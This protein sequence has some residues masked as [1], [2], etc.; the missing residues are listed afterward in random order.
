[1]KITEG[2]ESLLHDN[3]GLSLGERLSFG[4]VVEQ[5]SAFAQF[6]DQETDAVRLP[7]LQQLYDVRVVLDTGY[8]DT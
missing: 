4:D 8:E 5:L 2:V 7:R 6:G 1:M 3:G